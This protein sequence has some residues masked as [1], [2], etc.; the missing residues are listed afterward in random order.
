ME[1][2]TSYYEATYPIAGKDD[3]HLGYVVFSS[4]GS[5][6]RYTAKGE[7]DIVL[8]VEELREIVSQIETL[9]ELDLSPDTTV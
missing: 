3:K 6:F 5:P 7:P 1:H 4:D 8:T 2:T 9:N